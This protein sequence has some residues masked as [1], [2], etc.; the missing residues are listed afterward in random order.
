[1]FRPITVRRF[2]A[3]SLSPARTFSASARSNVARMSII[4][5]LAAEP[6]RVNTSTGRELVKYVIGSN[7][8]TRENQKTSWFRVTSFDDAEERVNYLTSLPRG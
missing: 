4:G 8:G 6:E 3:L 7:Y 1:M 5:R 2:S